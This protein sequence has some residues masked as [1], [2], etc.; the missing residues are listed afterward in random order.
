SAEGAH[1]SVPT[2]EV[3]RQFDEVTHARTRSRGSQGSNRLDSRHEDL[4]FD[5]SCLGRRSV[6]GSYCHLRLV[7]NGER[8]GARRKVFPVHCTRWSVRK[9]IRYQGEGFVWAL[10]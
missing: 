9:V 8:E 3:D 10:L 2:R 7:R 4:C 6:G 1:D 5:C